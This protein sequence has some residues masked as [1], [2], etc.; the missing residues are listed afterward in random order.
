MNYLTKINL[1]YEKIS[2]LS[3]L[4]VF[5]SQANAKTGIYA[6]ID[7][8]RQDLQLKTSPVE[9]SDGSLFKPSVSKFYE[10]TSYNPNFF[11]GF[12]A[13]Q[14][15]D[16]ELGYSM[17]DE[18]KRNNSTGLQIV[19]DN[20]V[21]Y[22]VNTKSTL[23]TQNIF[24]DIKPLY[25]IDQNNSLY[26]IFGFNYIQVKL[27][28]ALFADIYEI[29]NDNYKKNILAPTLGFGYKLKIDDNFSIRTQFK[30]SYANKEIGD[31][32]V[33]LK[34]LTQLGLGFAYNF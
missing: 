28:E 31:S 18:D 22:K 5:L 8:V 11:I 30:Y 34:S 21:N 4:L 14:N 24:V 23:K 16:F 1:N 15:L 12:N 10:T 3:L 20:G 19:D 25:Q 32:E 29:A 17:S 6:G 2:S 13:N 33:K 7:L 9:L 27:K 26:G